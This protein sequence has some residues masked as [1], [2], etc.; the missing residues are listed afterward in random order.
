MPKARQPSPAVRPPR[1][2]RSRPTPP[3]GAVEVGRDHLSRRGS[4]QEIIPRR[5]P[6]RALESAAEPLDGAVMPIRHIG[7]RR[8]GPPPSLGVPPGVITNGDTPAAFRGRHSIRSVADPVPGDDPLFLTGRPGGTT[9]PE[10][11]LGSKRESARVFSMACPRRRAWDRPL[12]FARA[13][14]VKLSEP[15][16][17][18]RATA[19][20]TI[21]RSIRN[22]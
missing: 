22:N 18:R 19:G 17:D 12:H 11:P 6:L 7:D 21:A 16:V 3:G 10:E 8:G 1:S 2:G 5:D 20:D 13:V 9:G 4:A 14:S 15:A